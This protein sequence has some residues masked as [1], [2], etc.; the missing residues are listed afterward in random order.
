LAIFFIFSDVKERTLDIKYC[1][2]VVGTQYVLLHIVYV[3]WNYIEIGNQNSTQQ[4]DNAVIS[5]LKQ[6][7]VAN[8]IT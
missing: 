7:N 3:I 8:I 5:S 6:A 2:I 1:A 4:P